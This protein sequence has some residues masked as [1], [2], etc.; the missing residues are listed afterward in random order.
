MSHIIGREQSDDILRDVQEI[1]ERW[2]NRLVFPFT[3]L[4]ERYLLGVLNFCLKCRRGGDNFLLITKAANALGEDNGQRDCDRSLEHWKNDDQCLMFIQT[5]QIIDDGQW[6]IKRLRSTVRLQLYDKSLRLDGSEALY[7][8]IETGRFLFIPGIR[9]SSLNWER[10][11]S[12]VRASVAIAGQSPRNVVKDG[13][14]MVD[15]LSGQNSKS[16]RDV[17]IEMRLEPLFESL[18]VLMSDSAFGAEFI[19]ERN[20]L[21]VEVDD[22]LFGPF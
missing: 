15:N 11:T 2:N 13:A 19:K 5:I 22:V 20:N 7:F 8:S 1:R 4:R 18:V 10:N 6:L 16:L 21:S 12:P 9:R 14:Q 3:K 17:T